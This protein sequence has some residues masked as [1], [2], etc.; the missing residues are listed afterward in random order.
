M[1]ATRVCPGRPNLGFR[2]T[3]IFLDIYDADLSC[4]V[5]FTHENVKIDSLKQSPTYVS[6]LSLQTLRSAYYHQYSYFHIT[7][8]IQL[9]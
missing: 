9:P 4:V 2:K 3:R 1:F 5:T 8:Q 6:P 7:H